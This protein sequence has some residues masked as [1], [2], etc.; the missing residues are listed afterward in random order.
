[1]SKLS[2]SFTLGKASNPHGANLKHNH[3]N[4]L[5]DNIDMKRIMNNIVYARQDVRA[6]YDELFGEAIAQ[7]NA[8][9]TR[10]D[11]KICDYY[12]QIRAGSR[13]EAFYEIIVQFGDMHTC[14]VG[15]E[16]AEIARKMLDEYMQ[17][18]RERNK[19]LHVF[20]STLHLD[21][22]EPKYICTSTTQ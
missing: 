22:C 18:F 2:T 10:N 3:R 12:E 17:G 6:A 20:S 1:M 5:A 13:E 4:F 8:K 21:E 14:G 9:Q 7:Y 16:N 11:R 19:N 15:S